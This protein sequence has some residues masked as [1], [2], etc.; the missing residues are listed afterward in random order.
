MLMS[1]LDF[2]TFQVWCVTLRHN[3]QL[4]VFLLPLVRAPPL[5]V[6]LYLQG[7]IARR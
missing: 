5:L 6:P 7:A 3:L 2:R 4:Q 1:Y